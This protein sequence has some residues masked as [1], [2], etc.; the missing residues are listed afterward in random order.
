MGSR[1]GNLLFHFFTTFRA[2]AE[3]VFLAVLLAL[4]IRHFVLTPYAVPNQIMAPTLES[5][6]YI[7]AYR[8][9][10][11]LRIPFTEWK[12]GEKMP[13]RGDLVL[14][15][16]PG[17]ES[18]ACVR[19]VVALPG[20]RIE[21][22]GERLILNGEMARYDAKASHQAGFQLEES[23][24]LLS[25]EIVISGDESQSRFGPVIVGPQSV[26]VLSD[27]RGMG[28]DSRQYGSIPVR[29]IEARVAL[30]WLSISW[31]A[32]SNARSF[33]IINWARVFHSPD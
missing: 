26:F 31:P 24:S 3:G 33:P 16:C 29:Q 13:Q 9:P 14:F 8:L 15:P 22:R 6:D 27:H 10:Y 2:Y 19:R 23:H 18:D 17:Q 20:D 11:G 7:L 28:P 21:I 1:D 30:V 32:E 4:A 12:W 25:Q 5:G